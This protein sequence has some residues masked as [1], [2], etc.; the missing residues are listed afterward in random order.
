MH[1]LSARKLT[2]REQSLRLSV[3]GT[4]SPKD[5]K[6]IPIYLILSLINLYGRL[7]LAREHMYWDKKQAK[8]QGLYKRLA[9]DLRYESPC[10]IT[11]DNLEERITKDLFSDKPS[12]TGLVTPYSSNWRYN[13]VTYKYDFARMMSPQLFVH[14]DDTMESRLTTAR[15]EKEY[16]KRK[17]MEDFL[18]PMVGSGEERAQLKGLVDEYLQIFGKLDPGAD[19]MEE[20]VSD[21][22]SV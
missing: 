4:F 3:N 16:H 12:T 11:Y 15:N 19:E 2:E 6:I 13:I 17:S 10:W 9:E 20:Q 14:G 18:E 22:L 8:Q 7:N 5:I 1:L 21:A